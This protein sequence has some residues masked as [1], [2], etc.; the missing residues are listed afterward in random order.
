L[1]SEEEPG[2]HTAIF[3]AFKQHKHV[4]VAFLHETKKGKNSDKSKKQQ[5]VTKAKRKSKK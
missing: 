1:K 3:V 4:I 2:T 5:T